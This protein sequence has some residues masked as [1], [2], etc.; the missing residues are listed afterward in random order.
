MLT[1]VDKYPKRTDLFVK[2][3]NF[4]WD[5]LIDRSKMLMP[6]VWQIKLSFIKQLVK[7]LD[8]NGEAFKYL[9]NFFLKIWEAEIKVSIHIGQ[10]IIGQEILECTEFY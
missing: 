6:P 10:E 3:N 1:T 4:K 7:A 2:K 8:K 9:Q 5:L